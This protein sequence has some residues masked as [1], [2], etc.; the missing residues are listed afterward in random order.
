[1]RRSNYLNSSP[2]AESN[3]ACIQAGAGGYGCL[4]LVQLHKGC[5]NSTCPFFKTEEQQAEE[6][7]KCR[8]RLAMLHP[9]IDFQTRKEV[10]EE[11]EAH[12]MVY[13]HKKQQEK[14]VSKILAI[15]KGKVTEY[16]DIES[17]AEGTKINEEMIRVAL[18]LGDP[19]HGVKFKRK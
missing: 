17:A 15:K 6:E 7:R 8:R 1:M 11:F 2:L 16:A 18:R 10:M 3:K 12:Q 9:D 13:N 19:I 4:A 5:H 14:K